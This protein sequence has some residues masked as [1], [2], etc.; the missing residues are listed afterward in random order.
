[1]TAIFGT[2]I[3][4]SIRSLF[5]IKFKAAQNLLNEGQTFYAFLLY[6]SV[7]LG[8]TLLATV[9]CVFVEPAAA[10]SGMADVKCGLNGLKIPR[11]ERIRTLFVKTIGVICSVASSLPAGKQGPMVHVGAAVAAGVSQGK[12]STVGF[13]TSWSKFQAFR[14]D[15]EKRDFISC[16]AAAGLASAF[17]APIGGVLYSLEAG[18]SFWHLNLT[19]RTFLC[20]M[21]ATST[22]QL[23]YSA[24]IPNSGSERPSGMMVFGDFNELG[25][26]LHTYELYELPL[27]LMLGFL[28][29]L[30][31]ASFVKFNEFVNDVRRSR[32]ET[33]RSK[34]IE[35][36]TVSLLF[37]CCAFSLPFLYEG[38][39]S[40]VPNDSSGLE[41]SYVRFTCKED[42]FNE[43]ASLIWAPSEGAIKQ[44]YHSMVGFHDSTLL[45]FF[46]LFFIWSGVTAGLSISAGVFV[47]LMLTGGLFGRI[48]GQ[49]CHDY[50]TFP[51]ANAGTWALLGSAAM[52]GGAT[53]LT[54]CLAVILI[55]ATG[56]IQYGLPL[57]ITL[58]GSKLVADSFCPGIYDVQIRERNWPFLDAHPHPAANSM[59]A[60][61]VMN[62][63]IAMLTQ[64][65]EVGAIMDVLQDSTV[66]CI[67]II[68]EPLAVERSQSADSK[69]RHRN[70]THVQDG[71]EGAE[72]G[73]TLPTGNGITPFNYNPSD[74]HAPIL[75]F[76][77]DDRAVMA[78]TNF[79]SDSFLQ[80][81]NGGRIYKAAVPQPVLEPSEE[82]K[83]RRHGHRFC[84]FI[85]RKH[86]TTILKHKCWTKHRP[87]VG[88]ERPH[89]TWDDFEARYPR[90]PRLCDLEVNDADKSSWVDLTAYM[91]RSPHTVF[92][93]SPLGQ[94]Y[95]LFRELGLRHLPV[96]DGNY[97]I[98]GLI[99]RKSITWPFIRKVDFTR[100]HGAWHNRTSYVSSHM[101]SDLAFASL[102]VAGAMSPRAGYMDSTTSFMVR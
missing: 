5:R 33:N 100:G 35:A 12:S 9:L 56:D 94:V 73:K 40:P 85:L 30:I 27:F 84:G 61:Q 77:P 80:V 88:S 59:T 24:V 46:V 65:C 83:Q 97:D 54:L 38:L 50:L 95:R 62:R 41:D 81:Q 49:L 68:K 29:G 76:S 52:L 20:T 17:G 26:T 57:M 99:T 37:S 51:T 13:D 31:G 86:L 16:G 39:C 3:A 101:E 22:V 23:L 70:S 69:L 71:G 75:G 78:S 98:V 58:T 66:H 21:I 90:Y 87:L 42:E 55:E 11:G 82:P 4:V 43:A 60:A 36:L 6:L 18:S 8:L 48:C 34:I 44:L 45:P 47:P 63:K 10:G 93:F 96:L 67:C 32:I 19:W 1:M 102:G 89:L 91:H 79:I 14:N 53:R 25:Q 74:P 28:G 2:I 92:M 72:G 7:N 15:R 64:V